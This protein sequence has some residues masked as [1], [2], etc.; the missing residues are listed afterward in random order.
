MVRND[1]VGCGGETSIIA[2]VSRRDLECNGT[3][4]EEGVMDFMNAEPFCCLVVVK[5]NRDVE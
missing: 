5:G 3:L 4:G 2:V 1:H